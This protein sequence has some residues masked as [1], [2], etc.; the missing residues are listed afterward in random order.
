VNKGKRR[1]LAANFYPGW[2]YRFAPTVYIIGPSVFVV[3]RP[4]RRTFRVVD[5][6]GWQELGYTTDE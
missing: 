2:A 5:L 1:K 6:S 3:P 4:M